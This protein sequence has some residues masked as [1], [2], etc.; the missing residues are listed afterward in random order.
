MHSAAFGSPAGTLSTSRLREQ[1][2]IGSSLE[3]LQSLPL[4]WIILIPDTTPDTLFGAE[5]IHVVCYSKTKKAQ[6][7]SAYL[8][9]IRIA[10]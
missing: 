9:V 7:T 5:H 8:L 6:Q 10:R 3:Q 2:A 4:I 1:R